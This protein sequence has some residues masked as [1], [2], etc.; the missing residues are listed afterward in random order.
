MSELLQDEIR[1][2]GRYGSDLL[3]AVTLDNNG[4]FT[5]PL[6]DPMH[7]NRIQQLLN[8][9]IKSRI[10]KQKIKGGAVVQ[11]S[12][13]GFNVK[14][15]IV[16]NEDGSIKHFECYIAC[17]SESWKELLQDT[18]KYGN[19]VYNINKKDKYGKP[20]LSEDMRKLIGYRIPTED[21]YS[22]APLYI[23]GFLPSE[24]GSAI[25]LPE[26]ITLLS[27]SDYDVDLS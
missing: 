4:E 19:T 18:D 14:P 11:V 2:N 23:K 16:F 5:I 26:E 17:P 8:S 15:Q 22:M 21:K 6:S 10:T 27:G 13:Y 7:S 12:S 1:K 20:I 9:I 25:V 24:S 3:R